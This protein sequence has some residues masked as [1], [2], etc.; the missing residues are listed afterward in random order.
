ML[1]L[2]VRC[3]NKAC[4]KVIDHREKQTHIKIYHPN[5]L[6]L[7]RSTNLYDNTDRF[8]TPKEIIKSLFTKTN[9]ADLE[10]INEI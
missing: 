9:N 10:G 7:V 6:S 2:L 3:N 1:M 4:L 8:M 5:F